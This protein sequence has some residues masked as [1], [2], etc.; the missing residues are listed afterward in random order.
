MILDIMMPKLDGWQ[1]CRRIR[2]NS[3]VPII[4]LTARSEDTDK[5]IG[6]E[7]GADDYITKPYNPM[8]VVARIK[9][10]IRRNYDYQESRKENRNHRSSY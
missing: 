3:F 9:A 8:E 7:Y 4:M 10:Q 2:E 6:F 1:V 5:L